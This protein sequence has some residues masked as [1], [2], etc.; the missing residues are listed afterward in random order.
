MK[1]RAVIFDM[2]GTLLNTLKDLAD[3]VNDGLAKMGFPT[4]DLESY[5]Y[6][7]GEG[8]EIMAR[9]T[10]PENQRNQA[11]V[12][13]LVAFI[14]VEYDRRWIENTHAYPGVPDLL[15]AL[16]DIKIKMAILS[17][18][19]H[20][21][22]EKMAAKLLSKWQFDYILGASPDAPRKPDPA[23]ALQIARSMDID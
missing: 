23:V 19:P 11:T 10:L 5:R 6:F 16:T 18:K 21:F 3:S 14:N 13:K 17:N 9:K 2:D 20:D 1:Y 8:R 15:N 4:H 22:T 7:V 12:D